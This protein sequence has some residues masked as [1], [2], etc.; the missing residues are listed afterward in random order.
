M[1]ENTRQAV[2]AFD[3]GRAERPARSVW[4]DGETLFSYG[5]A[6]ATRD[7]GTVVLNVTRYSK[8]TSEKQNGARTYYGASNPN[9]VTVD[10]IPRGAGRRELLDAA[11][12]T[13]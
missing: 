13:A 12:A 2:Q 7:G 10:G 4:T 1:R 3:A 5:T 8:T 11:K 9:V 6:I